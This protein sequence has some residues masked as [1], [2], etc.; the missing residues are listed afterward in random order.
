MYDDTTMLGQIVPTTALTP[1]EL[2]DSGNIA[3]FLA[4]R[5]FR[6]TAQAERLTKFADWSAAH[7]K[8]LL[9]EVEAA[10]SLYRDFV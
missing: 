6:L 3:D 7:A 8:Q 9:N 4:E 1:T 5:D 2:F 10:Y